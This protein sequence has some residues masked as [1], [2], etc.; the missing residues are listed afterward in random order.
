MCMWTQKISMM[1]IIPSDFIAKP[2]TPDRELFLMTSDTV[3]SQ[4]DQRRTQCKIKS[5]KADRTNG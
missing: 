5:R 4:R 1:R 2:Q 3:E